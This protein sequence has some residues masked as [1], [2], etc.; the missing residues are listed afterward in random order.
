[1]SIPVY[2]NERK[3]PMSSM[4]SGPEPRYRYAKPTD[5][6]QLGKPPHLDTD[7]NNYNL[8]VID[9][10]TEKR[11]FPGYSEANY[12][13]LTDIRQG[14]YSG[15]TETDS[16]FK[17]DEATEMMIR[18]GYLQPDRQG[19]RTGYTKINQTSGGPGRSWKST[20]NNSKRKN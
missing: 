20:S 17:E 14:D 2:K 3:N 12:F 19:G 7:I 15:T 8:P 13:S 9:V 6:P 11:N 1:M 4:V 5:K 16:T 18:R 10:Q